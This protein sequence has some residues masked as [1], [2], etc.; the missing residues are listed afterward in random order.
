MM[1]QSKPNE[2]EVMQKMDEYSEKTRDELIAELKEAG[3]VSDSDFE[4]FKAFILP[5]LTD[6]Q[7]KQLEEL[8]KLMLN[9]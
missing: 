7:A 4:E 2:E 5:M 3:E 6:E 9:N 8:R 1:N